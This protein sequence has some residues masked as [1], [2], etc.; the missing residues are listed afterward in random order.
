MKGK[1]LQKAT[2]LILVLCMT[3]VNFLFVGANIVYAVSEKEVSVEGGKVKFD[4]YFKD[5]QGNKIYT[6][7]ANITEG[8]TLYATIKLESGVLKDAKIKIENANFKLPNSIENGNVKSI[9][10]DNNEIYLKDL[11]AGYN[12]KVDVEIPVAFERQSTMSVDYFDRENSIILSG[13]YSNSENGKDISA[14]I[15]TKLAWRSNLKIDTSDEFNKVVFEDN[16]VIMQEALTSKSTNLPKVTETLKITAPKVL[17]ENPNRIVVLKNGVKV[18]EDKVNAAYNPSTGK[19]EIKFD[20]IENNTIDWSHETDT[21]KV[22]YI[23]NQ[24]VS[25]DAIATAITKGTS[26]IVTKIFEYEDREKQ[27]KEYS[28][29]TGYNYG[30]IVSLQAEGIS[31]EVYKG[32]MY[33]NAEKGTEF[34]EKYSLEVSDKTEIEQIELNSVKTEFA[35]IGETD[36]APYKKIKVNKDNLTQILG[37]QGTL[38]ITNAAGEELAV[39]DSANTEKEIDSATIKIKTSAPV[40]E[41]VLEIIATKEIKGN[42]GLN[43]EQVKATN[44]VETTLNV[45]TNKDTDGSTAK[46]TTELK[47]PS[48]KTAELTVTPDTFSTN[49][50]NSVEFQVKLPTGTQDTYLFKKPTVTLTLP[51]DVATISNATARALYAENE[52]NDIT[53]TV[54]GKQIVIAINGEQT[55]FDNKVTGGIVVIV[56]ANIDLNRSASTKN[57]KVTMSYTN[58]NDMTTPEPVEKAVRIQSQDKILETSKVTDGTEENSMIFETTLTNTT[59]NAIQ[60]IGIIGAILNKDMSQADFENVVK[61]TFST[62]AANEGIEITYSTDKQ[63]WS[64]SIE[65]ATYYKVTLK[66]STLPAEGT[67]NL[68]YMV[69][70]ILTFVPEF[71]LVYDGITEP[72]ALNVD[73][74]GYTPAPAPA[75]E[76]ENPEGT[77]IN[78]EK[79][80]IKMTAVNGAKELKAN[81]G[82]YAGQTI[83]YTYTIKNKTQEELK[84]VKIAVKNE[85]ANIFDDTTETQTY[86]FDQTK[87]IDFTS[88]KETDKDNAEFSL[89]NISANGVKKLTYQVRVKEGVETTSASAKIIADGLDEVN[90]EKT[91]YTV[92]PA[93]VKLTL[94]NGLSNEHPITVGNLAN[95]TLAIKNISGNILQNIVVNLTVPND[96]EITDMYNMESTEQ[97][98]YRVTFNDK[99]TMSFIINSM[100]ADEEREFVFNIKVVALNNNK[101]TI[102]CYAKVNEKDYYSNYT[103][104]RTVAETKSDATVEQTA[105]FADGASVKTGD[106][107]I[108]NIKVKNISTIADKF[109]VSDDVPKAA[110]ITKAYYKIGNETTDLDVPSDNNIVEDIKLESGAEATLTIETE[111]DEETTGDTQIENKAEVIGLY[112]TDAK[113][114]NAITLKLA[115]NEEETRQEEERE[116]QQDSEQDNEGDNNVDN[117]TREPVNGEEDSSTTAYSISGLAW[118][119]ENK[120]G[121]REASEKALSGI[122]VVLTNTETDEYVKDEDG[123]IITKTTDASGK[124]K[125]ENVAQGKY[126][127]IFKY[128]NVK[129][130]N[131]EYKVS[132]ATENTNSDIITSKVST[133]NDQTKY[134]MTDT[135]ILKDAS[136]ENID[137][138][139]IKNEIFDLKLDKFITKVTVQN[140]AGTVVKEYSKEQLAKVEI[141]AKALAASTVLVEYTMQVTNE[142]ELGGYAN[143]I[144]DYIP[145]DLNFNSEIN[146]QWYKSTDGNIHTTALSKEL[147]NPGESKE[148]K[149]I[150][151]KTMTENNTGLTTNKA[152][153]VKSNNDASIPDKDS[154]SGNNVSGEDDMSSA[155]LIISI[156]TGIG[157]TIGIITAIVAIA[158]A[159]VVFYTKKR[160]EANHE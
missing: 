14:T 92:L 124:Y 19:L 105:N 109:T 63:N 157:F 112:M 51:E 79:I 115:T 158:I 156:R 69:N 103:T 52:L 30:N 83:K 110:K 137:A 133:N 56:N 85:N 102:Q 23:Y 99:Q 12:S 7:D 20:F 42:A 140:S 100:E 43:K 78:S 90:V 71:Q 13:N 1:L 54:N 89:E 53:T 81:D 61:N 57:A 146:K 116:Q 122:Q 41:G 76:P 86:T 31:K 72:M 114:T 93:D 74:T 46:A 138:G 119:D 148:V 126:M 8:A 142:G 21:Y 49:N 147:I 33:S 38:T 98:G 70:N 104:V 64:N 108:Y 36:K 129:Y 35:N 65:N 60:N 127:V 9:S 96:F 141:D 154:T 16:R 149:L 75:E 24:T 151:T 55:S 101:N 107:V 121:I 39:I 32:F 131:T 80:D 37:D 50:T 94:T 88:E 153:I 29:E 5:S 155:E 84:N 134:G 10:Q 144:V 123:N 150:L 28:V 59:N 139:F 68:K 111:I 117:D 15:G 25:N 97:E 18:S 95:H 45:T 87:T 120:N 136:L 113:T 44:S 67:M 48:T 125:F 143:E 4:A 145:K 62:D 58:E 132:G 130:R 91:T 118:L 152:E 17:G 47:E 82:I 40:N 135:L 2:A 11:D 26:Q 128:D 34:D 160:K 77:V 27:S 106:K 22:I 6:K 66:S 3:M 159:G 73:Y